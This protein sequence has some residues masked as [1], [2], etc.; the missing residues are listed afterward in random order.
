M[1]SLIS[2]FKSLGYDHNME[3]LSGW[4]VSLGSSSA[5]IPDYRQCFFWKIGKRQWSE[6]SFLVIEN[7]KGYTWSM[8]RSTI[9]SEYCS[10]VEVVIRD[11]FF[12]IKKRGGLTEEELREM[13]ISDI[14]GEN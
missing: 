6:F 12:E 4:K 11:I 10:D 13:R 8:G 5:E 14:L 7:G 2:V 1:E 3:L 9:P